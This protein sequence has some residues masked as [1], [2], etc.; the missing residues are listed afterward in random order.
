MNK[1][2]DL[3]YLRQCFDYNPDTGSLTW[4]ERPRSHFSSKSEYNRYYSR[5]YGREV[6]RVTSQGYR[7]L[8]LNGKHY[9]CHR[10]VYKLY[11]GKDP[12]LHLDHI[13]GDTLDNR[14]ENIRQCTS[15]QNNH[16]HRIS[17]KNRSGYKGVSVL[18]DGRYKVSIRIGN[19]ERL[20]L[21]YYRNVEDAARAYRDAADKYHGEFKNYG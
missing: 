5:F 10:I 2:P 11:Y 1:L 6:G 17:I 12:E 9:G 3:F 14:I 21:G 4:S 19:E 18:K 7:E 20:H 16:N 15:T 8:R 13:N